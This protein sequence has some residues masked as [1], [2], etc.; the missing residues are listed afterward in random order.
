[1]NLLRFGLLFIFL[2]NVYEGGAQMSVDVI[3]QEAYDNYANTYNYTFWDDSFLESINSTRKFTIQTS[4]YHMSINYDSLK[5]QSLNINSNNLSK[6]E[7]F[8]TSR[9]FLFLAEFGG[10]MDYNILQN[11]AQ[12]YKKDLSNPT[13][14]GDKDSQLG[15]FGV[16]QNRRF[17]SS[18]LTNNA[19]VDKYFTGLDFANWHDRLKLT[20]HVRPTVNINDG[21][22]EFS[23][24][25]PYVYNNLYN[26]GT[27]YGFANA[28]NKGFAVKAGFDVDTLMVNGNLITVRTIEQDMLS[29]Q[30]YETSLVLY[31]INDNLSGSYTTSSEEESEISI[32]ANQTA[33]FSAPDPTINY[34]ASEGIHFLD[35]PRYGMGYTNCALIDQLQNIELELNNNSNIEKT[36][37][38]C[39]RQIPNVN[40][41]GFNSILRNDN[42]DPSG[43]PIQVSKNWHTST[44]QYYSGSWIREYTEIK[45]PPNTI[46]NI[47]YTR[48]GAKWGETY[49]AS[50]HQL[51]VAGAGI[52]KGG[53]LEAALG[54]FGE[55][56]THSP[57]YKFGNSNGCDL[58]PFLV[59]NQN[60]G[61]TSSQCN[62][63]GN[64][65]GVN[66]W[67]YDND[68]GERIFQKE[69]KTRFKRYSPNL[70]ETSVSAYSSDNKLKL[71][72]T[73]Y[74]NRSDDFVRVYYKVKIKALTNTPFN[75]LDI[76]QLGGDYYNFYA[77]RDVQYGN[78][79][80]VLGQFVP[81][82]NGS[83][84]YTT[85]H[86]ALTG[87]RPWIW[88][89]DG[90]FTF[91][92]GGINIDTNNGLIISNYSAQINGVS[93]NTPY[94]RERSSSLGFSGGTGLNP[95]SYCLVTPPG[96]TQL[97][98]GDSIEVML[99]IAVL[100]KTMGDYYGPNINFNTALSTYGNSVELF[101]REVQGNNPQLTSTTN[102]INPSYPYSIEANNSTAQLQLFGGKGYVPLVFNGVNDI[103]NPVLWKAIDNCWEEMDQSVHGKDYWQTDFN[104]NL[105]DF[106]LIYNVNQDMPY[107]SLALIHYYLGDVPPNNIMGCPCTSTVEYN[108]F[109]GIT[110]RWT[111]PIN[112]SLGIVP[113]NCHHVTIPNGLEAIL[114]SNET[115]GCYA[116]DV[117]PEGKL[118]IKENG[119]FF[120]NIE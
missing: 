55:T 21:Q 56:I 1:M 53:W 36:V 18:N 16:W 40:V 118:E 100:P 4:S 98:S 33:P 99:E 109:L 20:F 120:V 72:Y 73:F 5:I 90:I 54:S 94:F 51:S 92:Q 104:Y 45:I 107:D 35:I 102:A 24:E 19:P 82:N 93:S 59:T 111:D 69:V 12:L 8:T 43:L 61:G 110:D 89:G 38:L 10:D 23:I 17:V 78:S 117:H 80:G 116:I 96:T 115:G 39:F 87:S 114:Y 46:I 106:D 83:N 63:T 22:L 79:S 27:I 66:M 119:K 91:G 30:D 6:D 67:I 49:T 113:T 95:T 42:G 34:D 52:P 15:E 32:L 108:V 44:P 86:L 74:L 62:W 50:S 85:T 57:D 58:R 47:D 65:G 14:F 71:D 68:V 11:G 84:D 2:V 7:A 26:N 37:R 28:Q 76:F 3:P 88:A 112:W 97:L 29:G 60:Y 13:D 31:A 103:E 105:D 25:I 9:A 77:A 75:R 101:L 70:T 48:T 41:V 64:V 81:I